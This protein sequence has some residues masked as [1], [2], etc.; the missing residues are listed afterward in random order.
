MAL[1]FSD[2]QLPV[3]FR[4]SEIKMNVTVDRQTRLLTLDTSDF[5]HLLT[6]PK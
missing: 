2:L 3:G 6:L 4:V 5:A 1:S